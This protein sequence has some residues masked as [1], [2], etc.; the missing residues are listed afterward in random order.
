MKK[1]I[2]TFA[3][4]IAIASCIPP[5]KLTEAMDANTKLNSKYDSLKNK[6]ND[7]LSTFS[8]SISSLK[9]NLDNLKDSI[10]YYQG[11]AAT[12][13]EPTQGDVFLEQMVGNSLLTNSELSTI[14][15]ANG[16]SGGNNLWLERFKS[17][18]NKY[19][20][21]EVEVKLNKGFVF[22]DIPTKIMFA[23][24]SAKLSSKTSQVLTGIAEFLNAQ[25]SIIFL[26]EG[27]TDNKNFKATSQNNNW[28]LS[29]NRAAEVARIFQTKYNIDPRRMIATG[30]SQYL[31]VDD[32][33][34]P[35]GRL[36]NRRIRIVLMPSVKQLMNLN[37]Q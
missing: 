5:G 17:D 15:N 6:L 37:K 1:Y 22:I 25:P 30:R 12:I 10:S 32:N 33:N 20:S 7:T 29:V 35:T 28:T 3:I 4:I 19:T 8:A 14:K 18:I 21:S 27:H 23:S 24:G 34:T 31:P 9:E 13:P 36:N 11:I 2:S 26:I 16:K